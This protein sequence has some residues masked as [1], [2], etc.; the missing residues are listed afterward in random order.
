[1]ECPGCNRPGLTE[2]DFSWKIKAKGIRQAKCKLCMAAYE[3]EY[4]ST[5]KDLMSQ[6]N[7]DR[8][9]EKQ[10][11]ILAK[12]SAYYYANQ[13][14]LKERSKANYQKHRTTRLAAAKVYALKSKFGLTP[15]EVAAMLEVQGGACSIC[16]KVSKKGLVVDHCHKTGAVRGLLCRVCNSFLGRIDDSLE[17]L[18]RV[19]EYLLK[20]KPDPEQ[21]ALS[22]IG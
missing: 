20:Y 7:K 18:E 5:R 22:E 14:K 17:A 3:R 2:D 1:M 13:E 8:Y 11:E 10:P 9:H 21:L 19:K 6:K 4:R 15:E 12:K 16:G